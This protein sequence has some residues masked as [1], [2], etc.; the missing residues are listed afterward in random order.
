MNYLPVASVI[1]GY[2]LANIAMIRLQSD[3]AFVYP[4]KSKCCGRLFHYLLIN[5]LERD[6][7]YDI[8]G[9]VSPHKADSAK[10]QRFKEANELI[11]RELLSE[12]IPERFCEKRVLQSIH[13]R[14]TRILESESYRRSG[15]RSQFSMVAASMRTSKECDSTSS[16]CDG[17]VSRVDLGVD[18]S[19]A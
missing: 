5:M 4:R 2:E 12:I 17:T 9:S 14:I 15:K 13:E 19:L 8:K 1:R 7:T 10:W 16:T 18:E 3:L 6:T 11:I